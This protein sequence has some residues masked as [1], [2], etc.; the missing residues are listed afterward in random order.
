MKINYKDYIGK[1]L[2]LSMYNTSYSSSVSFVEAI[3]LEVS[4]SGKVKL[5]FEN[6]NTMWSCG[7]EYTWME[8]LS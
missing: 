5:K 8:E 6:G 4:N 7:T 1:R 2:L 3:V